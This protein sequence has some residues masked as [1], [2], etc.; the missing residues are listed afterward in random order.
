MTAYEQFLGSILA[1]MLTRTNLWLGMASSSKLG[2]ATPWRFDAD[3]RHHLPIADLQLSMEL[4]TV[5]AG[6]SGFDD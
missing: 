1:R 6:I 3:L 2:W 5:I 4:C